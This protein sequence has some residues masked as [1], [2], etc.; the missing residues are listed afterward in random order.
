L[1]IYNVTTQVKE[2]IHVEWLEWMRNDFIP[3]MIATELFSHYRIVKI[4]DIDESDGPTYAIQ[5]FTDS[6]TKYDQFVQLYS[7]K[8]SQKAIEKWK[9]KIF[10][11]RSLM[12]VI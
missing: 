11:F 5:Y 6:R 4:L 1:Y 2:F 7:N 8:L 12:E 9:D 10:S 3:E